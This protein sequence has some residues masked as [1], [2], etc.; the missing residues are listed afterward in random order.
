MP[1]RVERTDSYS[2]DSRD[3]GAGELNEDFL[4]EWKM[5]MDI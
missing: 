5:M 2:S 1:Q 3:A 4:V